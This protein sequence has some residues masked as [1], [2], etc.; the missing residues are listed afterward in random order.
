[1]LTDYAESNMT[2]T[3]SEDRN[4]GWLN[5]AIHK[6]F[7]CKIVE[8]EH[9]RLLIYA[10]KDRPVFHSEPCI[11]TTWDTQWSPVG[12]TW[13]LWTMHGENV[14]TTR[15]ITT[16]MSPGHPHATPNEPLSSHEV[17]VVVVVLR[18]RRYKRRRGVGRTWYGTVS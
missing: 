6:L 9:D 8:H 10:T 4:S 18:G 7:R 13:N 11:S 17:A 1:M 3:C 15:D 16:I 14:Q 5:E 2:V 12:L